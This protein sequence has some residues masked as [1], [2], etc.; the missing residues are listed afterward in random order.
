[1]RK[2][3]IL[4]TMLNYFRPATAKNGNFATSINISDFYISLMNH[5]L[6]TALLAAATAAPAAAQSWTEWKDP[7]VNAVNRL[8]IHADFFPFRS[9]A[10]AE[11]NDPTMASN[12]LSLNG[13]WRFR[14]EERIDD[15][16]AN[17]RNTDFVATTFDDSQWAT[18]PVPG[19]W[20]LNG[21]GQPVY[22]SAGYAWGSW[23]E[24][25]PPLVPKAKNHIGSY[26]RWV[27]VPAAWKGQRTVL[28]I[29]S[30]TSCVYLWVNGKFVGYGEDSKLEQEFDVTPYIKPGEKNLVC[31]K[32]LRWCDGSYVEDQDFIRLSGLARDTYL[33]A[34][35]AA[36]RLDDIRLTPVLN[37]GNNSASLRVELN[38]TG[39]ANVRLALKDANGTTVAEGT[40]TNTTSKKKTLGHVL[41]ELSLQQPKLW[42]AETPNLYT[43]YAT[44]NDGTR[45]LE[46]VRQNVGFRSVEI[47]NSQVL[48]NGQPVLIKGV[49][50]HE[51]STSGGYVVSREEME[52]DVR[53]MKELNINAVR[54]CHYPD[55][56]YWYELC[57]RYGLYMVAEADVESHGMGYDER[58]LAKDS[59]YAWTHLERNQRNVGRCFN[60]PAVIFW[61]LGNEAGYGPNFE[62]AYD[63]IKR[64]DPSRPVQYEQAHLTGKSDVYCPMYPSFE[65]SERYC[66]DSTQ[67]RPFIMCE[68]AHAMGN[69]GGEFSRYWD[70]VRKY[71]KYQGGFIWDWA[72]QALRWKDKEG[73]AFYSYDGDWTEART[74]SLNFNCNGLLNP[75]HKPNPHTWEVKHFYQ[76][77][78]TRPVDLTKGE[79][80]VY[81][82]NFFTSLNDVRLLWEVVRDGKKVTEGSVENL[83]VAPQQSVRTVLPIPTGWTDDKASEWLLNVR[84]VLKT[85]TA[86]LR[87]GHTLAEEQLVLSRPDALTDQGLKAMETLGKGKLKS[88][89]KDGRLTVENGEASIAWNDST[90]HICSYTVGGTQLLK[91]SAEITPNFWRAPTDNDYGAE[92]QK[93]M[94][95]WKAPQMKLTALTSEVKK[96][97][98]RIT[99]SYA[100]ECPKGEL[101]MVYDMAHDG[102][103]HV[104]QTLK[105]DTA[106][107]PDLFR[108]GLQWPMPAKFENLSYYGRGPIENYADRQ[109]ATPIGRYAQT[110]TEQFYP[111]VRPQETGLRTDLR[112]WR[113]TDAEGRG[114]E[115]TSG[116]PFSASALHYTIDQLDGGADKQPTH[117]SLLKPADVTN[118]CLDLRQ[119]GLG[120]VNA[121]GATPSKP[122][123]MPYTDYT[124]SFTVR[125]VK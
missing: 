34:T 107:T 120:C 84:Y 46:T 33:F 57:D 13:T 30:A 6:F 73:R 72:D 79:V 100:M 11:K 28:H 43:L 109:A 4:A 87:E 114:I 95:V 51:M 64:T 32:M 119:M 19:M 55:D 85:D 78:W 62:A 14:F 86:L 82:E 98:A 61:S 60:H 44:L 40:A 45:D 35:P 122:Y 5:Y 48:V 75:E 93:K 102:S 54:T 118:L 76:N 17:V 111:Y 39:S 105:A 27:D 29:G 70:M 36:T 103:L 90:G 2:A 94:A 123:L 77:I 91:D 52:S 25:T 80:D 22:P 16:E 21:Y 106:R 117:S 3:E 88:V 104:T 74:G 66:K 121:W 108:F 15:D 101:T 42:T 10:D 97:R 68:Y 92:L 71:P 58:T 31:F 12:Y 99:A 69:S 112:S 53:L 24:N 9:A 110:V 7:N 115:V 18:M 1:M 38:L 63:W 124:F 81:N 65:W 20:E 41:A 89:R 49:N 26:R 47:K 23:A 37:M 8:P 116:T 67:L 83:R 113:L 50:R 56:P 96:G 59:A 125:P